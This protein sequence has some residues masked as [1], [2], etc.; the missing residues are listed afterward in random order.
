MPFSVA[1]PENTLYQFSPYGSFRPMK[2]TVLMPVLAMWSTSARAMMSS[3][4][5]VLNTHFF[6]SFM[7]RTTAAVPTGASIGTPASAAN[8][9]TPMALGE[10][11]G[12]ISAS[13]FC[14]EISFLNAVTELVESLA[15]SSEMYSTVRSPIFLGSNG[16]VF[17]CGMPTSAVGPVEDVTTPT[18]ICANAGRANRAATAAAVTRGSFFDSMAKPPDRE[19]SGGAAEKRRKQEQRGNRGNYLLLKISNLQGSAL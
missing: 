17:F 19:Q 2:P 12:P 18:F 3:F 14:S 16:T 13:T 7:G 15:S 1:R 8:W 4:C 5:V 11:D 10:P 6:W 9:I